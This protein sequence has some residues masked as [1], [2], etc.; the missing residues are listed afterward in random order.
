MRAL[1][2]QFRASP[3]TIQRTVSQLVS[4]GLI[5]TRPGDGSFVAQPTSTQ[6]TR[7]QTKDD[8]ADI[9]WQA[10][11][12]GR[13]PLIPGGLDYL[14]TT[15]RPGVIALDS[16]FPDQSLQPQA[17]LGRAA[18]RA[19][20]RPESWDRSL[21]EGTAAL[22]R[23]FAHELREDFDSADVVI[24]PGVQSA[25]DSV[26]RAFAQPGDCVVLEEPCYPGAIAAATFSGL[27]IVPVP[28]DRDGMRTD[29]FAEAVERSG[30]RLAFVQPRHA[31]PS[32]SVL[33]LQR[34]TELLNIAHRFGMFVLEDDWVRDL[35]LNLDDHG[36]QRA[37]TPAPLATL[38]QF[39]H[40][41]YLRSLSKTTAPGIRVGAVIARGQAA[42]RLRAVRVITDFFVSPLLQY[43]VLEL[44]QDRG[45]N[46][47]LDH[48]RNELRY[49]RDLLVRDLA[50]KAP[51][52][53]IETPRG[54][55]ALWA[56]LPSAID[57][58]TFVHECRARGVVLGTGRNY[59]LSEPPAGHVR[60]S[61]AA[62]PWPML[63]EASSRIGAVHDLLR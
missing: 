28:S 23:F 35:D 54:G 31:N 33:G 38:D 26:F 18:A 52:L 37:L 29:L 21:P 7:Q 53:A 62:A 42:A 25:I 39:G 56:R 47:H 8:H 55:V 9:R 30:A 10:S 45:W 17:L 3:L 43:T 11:L 22:R 36:R 63:A 2:R 51:E 32:G 5:V 50:E 6:D 24:T 15:A 41:L 49:R 13:A 20:K 61:F 1:Q 59:W 19:A 4:E 57:E 60:I 34:R 27:R 48:M 14:A 12:L 44:M 40:V 58:T 46:R 16:G